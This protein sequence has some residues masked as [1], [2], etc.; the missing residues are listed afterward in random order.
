MPQVR[1]QIRINAPVERIWVI[2]AEANRIPEWQTNIVTL[3]D[4]TG[5]I[6]QV[7]TRYT[8]VNRLLGRE[9]EGQWEVTRAER[10]R[11]LE[12][13]G[14][15]PGGGRAVQRITYSQADGGT[16]V[17]VDFDYEL[18]GGFLGQFANRLFVERAVQRDI[19]HSLE[20]FKALCEEPDGP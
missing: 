20:N 7:G 13:N 19:R 14:S 11:S 16:D 17:T 4:V 9:I 3:R 8:A 1:E 5:P 12:I 2:G 15:A 18:P 6:D 10:G